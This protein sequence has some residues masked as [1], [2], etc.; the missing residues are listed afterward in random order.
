MMLAL[1]GTAAAAPVAA[2]ARKAKP[3]AAAE[4]GD[5]A[6]AHDGQTG[7]EQKKKLS[8]AE[9]KATIDAAAKLL[10]A[11][12]AEPAAAALTSTLVAGSLPPAIMAK[13]LLYRG[14]A[15][16]QLNKPAQAIADLTSALWLKG[17]LAETDRAEALKQ[18]GAAYREAGLSDTG[19]VVAA[20][21]NGSGSGW[22]LFDSLF[23][24]APSPPPPPPPAAPQ[25]TVQPAAAPPPAPPPVSAPAEAEPPP[26][27]KAASAWSRNT[28]VH[29]R[30]EAIE[31]GTLRAK[32]EGRFRIQIGMARTHDQAQEMASKVKS[33]FADAVGQR[34]P[35]ID[36]TVVGNMGSF[37]RVRIGP[38]ASPQEGQAACS[39]L[40]G[41]G[42]DCLVVAQ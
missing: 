29:N 11:G 28:Q 2:Q 8:P 25:P 41:S 3:P 34:E 38:F 13:A 14:M 18:R 10:A 12:K 37:Y 31:T 15:Y 24:S 36:E 9:A 30:A 35:E 33:R 26:P 17:G 20:L 42:F 40:K 22:N 23:G 19:A 6:G 7:A 5:A 32:P 27:P 39:K 16:R 21:P 4:D 1:A